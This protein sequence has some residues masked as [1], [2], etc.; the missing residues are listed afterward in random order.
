MPL[1]TLIGRETLMIALPHQSMS[2]FLGVTQ[3]VGALRNKKTVA[4]SSTEAEY[5][6]VATTAAEIN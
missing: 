5:R 4:Q 2:C 6:V 1:Q 3:L